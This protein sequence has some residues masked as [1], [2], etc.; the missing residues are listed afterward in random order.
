[1]LLPDDKRE[2]LERDWPGEFRR[3]VLPLIDEDIFSDLYCQ[4]N[5]RPNKPVETIVG[6]LILKEIRN[7]TDAEALFN[8]DFNLAWHVA[9]DLEPE[10]AH[11]CQKTLHTF[12]ARIMANDRARVLFED[13]VAK[14]LA[15]LGIDTSNQRLDS[16]HVISNIARLTRLRLFCETMRVFLKELKRRS[17]RKYRS[18]PESWRRR[19][20]KPDG[21][22]SSY[23]DARSAEAKRRMAVCAR[24]VWRLVDR[25]RGDKRVVKLE[26]YGLLQRLFE[27]QC[28]V[29][30]ESQAAAEGDADAGEEAVPVV[31]KEA[32]KV[33]SDSMQS[34][35][36][37]DMTYN[38]HK[39]KGC[40]VQVAETTDNGDKPEIITYSDVTPSCGSDESVPVP[41]VDDLAAR[42]IQPGALITD[43]N[44]GSTANA[45]ELERKGTELVAPVAGQKPAAEEESAA[46]ADET[47][48]DG[49]T[50]AVCESGNDAGAPRPDDGRTMDKG[51]FDVDVKGERPAKCPAGKE[52]TEER[53]DGGT[54]KVTL[55]FAAGDCDAC[56]LADR[57][58]AKRQKNGTRVLNTTL[59]HSVL[60]R[61]RRYQRTREFRERYAK[62]AGIEGTNSEL[63]RVHGLGRLRVRGLL[64]VRLAVRLKALACNVKRMV[65]YLVERAR[66]AA[67]AAA[68]EA[69]IVEAAA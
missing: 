17:K 4:D 5:G 46:V 23:D 68:A 41:V 54:G 35:H 7:L 52:A 21:S 63:K 53:C 6:V 14:I 28:E 16:T 13:M 59:H 9:L 45:I 50:D 65:K 27:E 40:E 8:L 19:Y 61:R 26:S 12:R 15:A 56:P 10:E 31:V 60:S 33:R 32:K 3:S 55:T 64:R 34:P 22:D 51:E 24:D 58:P 1:M 49:R 25:F 18:V 38:A 57:C 47:A 62:R 37:P 44:Y 42:R 39:G 11:C 48:A 69:Q 43:T 67:K 66:R 2:R 29:V 36:D 30:S 20:V